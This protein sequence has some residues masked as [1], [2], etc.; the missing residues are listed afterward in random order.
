MNTTRLKF[1]PDGAVYLGKGNSFK[2]PAAP[3]DGWS[4]G[5]RFQR[6]SADMLHGDVAHLHYAAPADSEVARLNG[7]EA[8]PPCPSENPCDM[9]D[10]DDEKLESMKQQARV[11]GP[12]IEIVR[13]R[14]AL[15]DTQAQLSE[16][17]RLGDVMHREM[18]NYYTDA[19]DR[20]IGQ[21]KAFRASAGGA[22]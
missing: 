22:E 2:R 18:G 6:W 3:F 14:K 20:I 17:V 11:L 1:L 16:A 10:I 21:W 5:E 13:L 8:V 19:T 7:F 9:P 4:S 12:E 15:A